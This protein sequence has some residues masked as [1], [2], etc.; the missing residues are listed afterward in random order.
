[1][2]KLSVETYRMFD[3]V[4]HKLH[5]MY[6]RTSPYDYLLGGTTA[7]LG[8]EEIL[9]L[10]AHNETTYRISQDN[11]PSNGSRKLSQ[12]KIFDQCGI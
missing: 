4:A 3:S 5:V 10:M 9:L 7:M 12:W 8:E 11:S 6:S 2:L 1:M